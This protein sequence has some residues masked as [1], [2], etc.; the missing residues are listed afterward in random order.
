MC[1][2]VTPQ[3]LTNGSCA[4]YEKEHLRK[5]GSRVPVLVAAAAIG[6]TQNRTMKVKTD[7]AFLEWVRSDPLG[8]LRPHHPAGSIAWR[9]RL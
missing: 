9:S 3:I 6:E 8:M 2:T 7:A 4:A 1:D 5:D